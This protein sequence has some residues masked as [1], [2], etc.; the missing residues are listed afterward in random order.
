MT[1]V[2]GS[3]YIQTEYFV[4]GHSVSLEAV[5]VQWAWQVGY[6]RNDTSDWVRFPAQAR[7]VVSSQSPE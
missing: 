5:I 2:Q 4:H 3:L 7:N 1:Y 6:C